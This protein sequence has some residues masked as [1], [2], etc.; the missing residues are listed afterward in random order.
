M[1]PVTITH[2]TYY[3]NIAKLYLTGAVFE[4]DIEFSHNIARQL[5]DGSYFLIKQNTSVR[6]CH[7]IGKHCI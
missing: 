6:T 5:F 2:N 7:Y 1:G 3:E 4:Y